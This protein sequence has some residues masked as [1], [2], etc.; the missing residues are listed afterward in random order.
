MTDVEGAGVDQLGKNR[1]VDESVAKAADAAVV[2]PVDAGYEEE[3]NQHRLTTL[4]AQADLAKEE[5]RRVKQQFDQRRHFF[6]WAVG[7]ISGVLFGSAALMVWY[8]IVRGPNIEPAVM[9][10]WL[11]SGLVETLGL[12]YII[13]NYLFD[14]GDKIRGRSVNNAKAE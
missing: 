9:I 8:V 14:G 5:V 11:S 10:A 13:A 12:G 4:E 1:E 6:G 3:F 2:A 7:T